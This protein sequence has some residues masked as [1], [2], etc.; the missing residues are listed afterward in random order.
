MQDKLA[1][2]TVATWAQSVALDF[3]TGSG[4]GRNSSFVSSNNLTTTLHVQESLSEKLLR[5]VAASVVL[6]E[7][8]K[9]GNDVESR[10][11]FYTT[12]S[13]TGCLN[14]TKFLERDIASKNLGDKL[15]SLL[16]ALEGHVSGKTEGTSLV[17]VAAALIVLTRVTRSSMHP[18]N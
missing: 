12:L 17:P 5:W 14:H 6:G 13:G 18:G 16:F 7:L 8:A 10:E 4:S 9:E 11:K 2:F 15:A 1:L 3:E